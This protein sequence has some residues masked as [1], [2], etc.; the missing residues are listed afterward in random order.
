MTSAGEHMTPD[1]AQLL[2]PARALLGWMSDHQAFRML[3]SGRDDADPSPEDRARLSVARANAAARPAGIDQAGI[4]APLPP[5]LADHEA[6]LRVSSPTM[7]SEGWQL[8]LVD[9]SRVCA[10]Q[11]AVYTRPARERAGGTG[12]IDMIELARITV[13]VVARTPLRASFDEARNAWVIVSPNR[14]LRLIGRFTAPVPGSP[15]G[16]ASGETPG[17]GFVVTVVPSYLQIAEFRG[18]H[19]LRDGYH[20]ALGL[21]AA[22]VRVVPALVCSVATIEQLAVPGSLPQDAYMGDRPPL[23]GDYLDDDVAT[24]VMLPASQKMILI[25]GM[26]IDFLS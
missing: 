8:A 13:P 25:Q 10:F 11:P 6:E 22:G 19:I 5:E 21:L 4:L 7:F 26:E 14:N 16:G 23:L 2:R 17:F 15:L 20:R 12:A 3:A 24:D 18:R 9:L 1:E